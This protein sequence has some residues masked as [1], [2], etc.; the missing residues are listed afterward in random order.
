VGEAVK[1]R[2]YQTESIAAIIKH[3]SSGEQRAAV[4]LPTGVGKT[5]IFSDLA[6]QLESQS[7]RVVVLVHREE[8][9]HQTVAKLKAM[10]VQSVGIV[11]AQL[12]QT[13]ARVV[14]ATVQTLYVERRLEQ[15]GGVDVV[16]YD[17]L[18]HAAAARNR[19]LLSRLGVFDGRAKAVG[20][21]AT[22]L[23]S[24]DAR[25]ANDWDVVFERDVLWAIEHGY[26]SDVEAH[27]IR[28][29]DLDTSKVRVTAG[30]FSDKSL[31]DAMTASSARDVIPQAWRK[32]AEGRPTILFAPN[33]ASC[34][35]LADGLRD[36][37]IKTE[38]VFG[39][40][41]S[42]ERAAVYD[43][44]RNGTTSVLAS[45]GVLTE[46]F[47]IPAISCAILARP[48]KS[49]GLWQQMAGRAL[50]L[51]PGKDKAI[52]LDITGDAV[53]HSLASVTDLSRTQQETE[54]KPRA[55]ALCSCSEA[56]FL[57]CCTAGETRLECRK[58]KAEGNCSC[59]CLCDED[60][61]D[62]EIVLVRGEHD[63]EVDL[64]AG[65]TSVWLKT[66]G[67]I[68]FIPTRVGVW[69][70]AQRPDAPGGYWVGCSGSNRGMEGGYWYSP[71]PMAETDAMMICQ[72][73]AEDISPD[74][75]SRDAKWRKGKATP[76]QVQQVSSLGYLA[77][78]EAAA[79][80]R[81]PVSDLLSIHFA[82][83][84]L[85]PRIGTFINP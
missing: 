13:W 31:G 12:N 74:V 40:T 76:A 25:L 45:V 17:E 7:L 34:S 70:I 35:N 1:L 67:G 79:L 77:R 20:F 27:S 69:F 53:N 43:R 5:V 26:I 44:I 46:G 10:G 42:D 8:L 71:E 22:F 49:R 24:D 80:R 57:L 37:G 29:P 2:S 3:W 41:R 47:D 48:T 66:V 59:R 6:R 64:F 84:L 33:I 32:Y 72:S 14:V 15:L 61:G 50:R 16:I 23:R 21:T 83:R 9:V 56:S 18:H 54:S 4:I 81:G 38:V 36:A 39:T 19:T 51:F 28:V 75:A 52:L 11:K 30:D 85:D 65:S 68:W 82:S 55:V 62:E 78:E 58:R 60:F 73:A 63:V